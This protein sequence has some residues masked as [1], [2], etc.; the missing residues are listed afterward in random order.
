ME[1]KEVETIDRKVLYCGACGLPPEY[2]EF[3]LDQFEKCKPWILQH[4]P[5]VYPELAKGA[6]GEASKETLQKQAQTEEKKGRGQ[7][8]SWWESEKKGDN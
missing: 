2:C 3:N 7:N 8:P 1:Q 5:N 6:S 4:C